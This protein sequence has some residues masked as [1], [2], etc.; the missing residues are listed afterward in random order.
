LEDHPKVEVLEKLILEQLSSNPSS[1]I[2]IFTQY[3][4]TS[5]YLAARLSK[6]GL[7]VVRFVGQAARGQDQGLTQDQQSLLLER[8]RSGDIKVLVAT[9]I[10]EEGLDIPSVDLVIFYEPVPSE[11]RYIQRKGRTGRRS[12]GKVVILAAE[13]TLDV[14][15]LAASRRMAEIMKQMV[16]GLN[17]EL[18]PIIRLG[19]PPER[20]Q[21]S[22]EFIF[23][24]EVPQPVK[25]I[26][27]VPS[28][29]VD[30]LEKERLSKFNREVREAAKRILSSVLIAGKRGLSLE[31]LYTELEEEGK[32]HA[33]IRAAVNRLQSEGQLR[34]REGKL[35]TIGA[36]AAS[37]GTERHVF[38]VLKVQ[39]G[40]AILLVDDRFRAVVTSADYHGPRELLRKGRR[41]S[42]VSELYE[43]SGTRYAR[44]YAI[45]EALA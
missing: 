10:G 17:S 37:M 27:V 24:A 30:L 13:G 31:E 18:H 45:D 44:I 1:R 8:F 5:T 4:D 35:F 21:L 41:F 39:L 43:Y 25:E 16:K 34:E 7:T 28:P 19:T 14:N 22:P 2:I 11:I 33:T 20:N 26:A 15:Y 40:E 6:L 23:E 38:E 29:E 36:A 32:N 3:R 12:F 42:A 9:S